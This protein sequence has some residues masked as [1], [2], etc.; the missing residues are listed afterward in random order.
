M[1]HFLLSGLLFLQPD[2]LQP[3]LDQPLADP[4]HQVKKSRA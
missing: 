4:R 2:C 1:A 3:D